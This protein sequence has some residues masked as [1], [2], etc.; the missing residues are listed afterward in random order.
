MKKANY[1]VVLEIEVLAVSPIEAA[2]EV[3]TWLDKGDTKWCFFVQK[4][5]QHNDDIF[6]IDLSEDSDSMVIEAYDYI[7]M[8]E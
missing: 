6:N 3:Q 4:D 8:I 2:K 7:P 5:D 1:R